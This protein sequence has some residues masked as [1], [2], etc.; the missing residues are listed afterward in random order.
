FITDRVSAIVVFPDDVNAL[1]PALI[2][3]KQAGIKIIG[4][5]AF[6]PSA[7]N[8][9]PN[10]PA[11]YDVNLDWGYVRGPYL[12]AKF[13]AK[14]LHGKGNVVGIKIPV[15]VPSLDAM[16]S[17]YQ[18]YVTAGNPGIHW[19]GTLPDA[20]DDLAGARQAMA[21]AITR[22]HGDIQAVMAYTDIAG[23]GAYQ[24]LSSAGIHNVVIIGQ[25]GNQTGVDAL[26]A[27]QI[28]ADIDTEPYTAAVWAYEMTKRVVSG[29]SFPK[30][31]NLP[32]R[33]LT[34]ANADSYVPWSTGIDN[35]KSGKTSLDVTFD[36]N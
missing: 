26:K 16:L 36:G 27:G 7:Y 17:A 15:P 35:I 33:I 4:L 24:A 6:L 21:D 13:V 22:Y 31:A 8:S 18:N 29:S 11:P 20:T 12:E 32:I 25:Q 9:T 10:V 30:F 19:L 23:I 1:N 34:Q 14:Q 3:A 2:K 5:N 28:Q